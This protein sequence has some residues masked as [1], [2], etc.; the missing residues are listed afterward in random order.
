MVL[1]KSE[2]SWVS[3][4]TGIYRL[5]LQVNYCCRIGEWEAILCHGVAISNKQ[6]P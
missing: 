5:L 3:T 4:K 2:S 6:K 1:S